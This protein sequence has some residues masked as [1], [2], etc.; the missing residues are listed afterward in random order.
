MCEDS[1]AVFQKRH[2]QVHRLGFAWATE[3]FRGILSDVRAAHLIGGIRAA[4][5]EAERAEHHH[6]ARGHNRWN[7]GCLSKVAGLVAGFVTAYMLDQV[8]MP[9][10]EKGITCAV[11]F[12]RVM[13]TTA[14]QQVT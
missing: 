11:P 1:A 4:A 14:V 2:A 6:A 3:D 7:P 5:M 8:A 9:I 13:S 10:C 12:V